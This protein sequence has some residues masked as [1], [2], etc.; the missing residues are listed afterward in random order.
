MNLRIVVKYLIG[1]AVI[2]GS[3]GFILGH[4]GAWIP[5]FDVLAHFRPHFLSMMITGL[6]TLLAPRHGL[7]FLMLGAAVTLG[8]HPLKAWIDH[9]PQGD[10][11]SHAVHAG[12]VGSSQIKIISLNSWHR[13]SDHDKLI[14]YLVDQN[15]DIVILSEFGPNKRYL[16]DTL[17]SRYPHQTDCTRI[18]S[19]SMALLS[20]FEFSE[21][22]ADK[23]LR[24][25]PSQVRA[26]FRVRGQKLTVIG[27]HIYRP[28]DDL[29]RHR[30]EMRELGEQV[31]N[32]T[33]AVVVAGDFNTTPWSDSFRLFRDESQLA[34]MDSYLPSWPALAPQLA[35]DHLFH[36]ENVHVRS[37]S[38]HS[39]MGSDHLPLVAHIELAT[40][41]A[42]SIKKLAL[43]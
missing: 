17:R 29:Q 23:P 16:L 35:I 20:K 37:I 33:G 4:L 19:C 26:T 11:N 32:L 5:Q 39:A 28:I 15:A 43:P 41:I 27:T 3:A 36:S 2:A 6:I 14:S 12:S 34:H 22:G 31:R 10:R 1:L 21:Q 24:G 30:R 13:H 42:G 38:T 40:P 7:A 8:L 9:L 25:R 18:W